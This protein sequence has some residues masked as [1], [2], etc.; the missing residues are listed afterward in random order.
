MKKRIIVLAMTVF[1]LIVMSLQIIP[2]VQA[3]GWNPHSEVYDDLIV[4]GDIFPDEPVEVKVQ[5][6]RNIQSGKYSANAPAVYIL[7]DLIDPPPA[8][9]PFSNGFMMGEGEYVI[10]Y[11]INTDT[12][13]GIAILK[14]KVTLGAMTPDDKSDDG[15]FTGKMFWIGDLSILEDDTIDLNHAGHWDWHTYWRGTG[16]YAGWTITQN[17]DETWV[18]DNC[19]TIR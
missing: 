11:T 8:E 18:M 12:G 4:G 6:R 13:E 3:W 9:P 17:F 5:T 2:T 14:T 15:T 16:A 1:T 19:L 7:W 10:S